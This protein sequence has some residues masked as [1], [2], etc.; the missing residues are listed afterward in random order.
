ML[1]GTDIIYYS[2]STSGI[3]HVDEKFL[4]RNGIKFHAAYGCNSNAVAEY[5]LY[6][7]LDK[8]PVKQ[9]NKSKICVGIIGMGNI[10]Q[11]VAHYLDS[12]G[13]YVIVNDPFKKGE[14]VSRGH[15]DYV[16][17][18][19]LIS[20]ANIITNHVPLTD[21][22]EHPTKNLL[23][24][25]LKN[26]NNLKLFI[27]TSRG[28][29]VDEW[30]LLELQKKMG[31]ETIIDVW[32]DEPKL[33]IE[34]IRASKIATPHVAGH[35]LNGKIMGSI[36]ST[37]DLQMFFEKSINFNFPRTPSIKEIHTM[38]ENEII[39]RL[40]LFRKIDQDSE[41]L[42]EMVNEDPGNTA[43]IFKAL[44]KN[45]PQRYECLG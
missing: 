19:E 31:F 32:E 4:L 43:G 6:S 26:A 35:S 33:N 18:D 40:N 8:Y 5:V 17:L 41:T 9:K 30:K 10:G 15:Y 23:S 39:D 2:T 27:H 11:Q 44:R 21:S 36:M 22:G 14:I 24:D 37:H 20:Q 28:K 42:K 12:M 38:K 16:E 13:F 29:V 45:Y 3:D 34:L 1:D 25:N 7:I